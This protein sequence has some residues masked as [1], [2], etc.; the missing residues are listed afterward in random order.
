MKKLMVDIGDRRIAF[1]ESEGEGQVVLLI[2]GNSLSA[3]SFSKQIDGPLGKMYHLIAVDLPGH[4]DSPPAIDPRNNY[5][6]PGYAEIILALITH[7]NLSKLVLVGH[8]LGGHIALE[9]SEMSLEIKGIIIFGTPPIGIPPAI[10]EAFLDQRLTPSLFVKEGF[11]IPQFFID[12]FNNTDPKARKFLLRNT[13]KNNF[14]DEIDIVSNLKI[15]LAI[16]HGAHDKSISLDYIKK[17]QMPSL[18]K[19]EVQVIKDAGHSPQWET[20]D[21]FNTI[22]E[23]F[24][25]E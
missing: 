2:H 17:I 5:G 11:E 23:E 4:G 22:L 3:K 16:I 8:S 9:L 7:L 20:P 15:P 6:L 14:K 13:A 12:D 10:N 24:V 18:W 1:H 25:K 21:E 19:N